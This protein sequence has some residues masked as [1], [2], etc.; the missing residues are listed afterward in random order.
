[1]ALFSVLSISKRY[2]SRS[3]GE[4]RGHK[5]FSARFTAN[6]KSNQFFPQGLRYRLDINSSSETPGSLNDR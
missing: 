2:H 3:G 6:E 4:G 1:M 5:T